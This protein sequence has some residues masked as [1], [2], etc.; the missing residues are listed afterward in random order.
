MKN[1][2]KANIIALFISNEYNSNRELKDRLT[3]DLNGVIGDKFY[4]KDIQRSVL[5]SSI[6]SYKLALDNGIKI[7]YGLLGE[8]ILIDKNPYYLEEGT[9]IYIG[10]VI[11][12]ITALC[13]ICNHLSVID[14]K[15]PKLL[16]DDRGIFA[17]VVKGGEITKTDSF[18]INL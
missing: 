4:N 2:S 13:T 18:R 6:D 10:D 14:K 16:K 7:D 9:K 5:I 11:L 1:N 15:L 8:N 17:K 12:E 3:F